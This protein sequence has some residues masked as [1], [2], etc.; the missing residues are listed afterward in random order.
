MREPFVSGLGADPQRPA[1]PDAPGAP[2]DVLAT[3]VLTDVRDWSRQVVAELRP[4]TVDRFDGS[5]RI[6]ADEQAQRDLDRHET[7][8][9]LVD[10]IL[11]DPVALSRCG[12][13]LR[14][15]GKGK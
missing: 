11:R 9:R 13:I 2:Q 1:K 3:Q 7:V 14:G 12:T 8:A 6:A 5:E 15:G 10:G 4:A